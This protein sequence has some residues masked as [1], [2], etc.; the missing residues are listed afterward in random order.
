MNQQLKYNVDIILCID[1][2]GS[3]GPVINDVK[4]NALR[5]YEDLHNNMSAKGK[6]IDHLRIKVISFRD[7][8]VD[9]AKSM[10]SSN[11]FTRPDE[12]IAF[13]QFVNSIY[14][15]GGGDEPE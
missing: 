3:M 2:T 7:Y 10:L 9:G 6:S 11:V 12:K 4:N 1:S 5:F 15:D 14:A 13:S 8:Y